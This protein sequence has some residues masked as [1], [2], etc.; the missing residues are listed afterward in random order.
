MALPSH[1]AAEIPEISNLGKE[2]PVD[3]LD[4]VTRILFGVGEQLP[5]GHAASRFFREH[6]AS[7]T[8]EWRAA[9]SEE[10]PI[11]E[12][13]ISLRLTV[14]RHHAQVKLGRRIRHWR[15]GDLT[16]TNTVYC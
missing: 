16:I 8:I 5:Q 9:S 1:R 7:F 3:V 2:G 12:L 10:G 11:Q 13:T 15:V 4:K 6:H 14:T